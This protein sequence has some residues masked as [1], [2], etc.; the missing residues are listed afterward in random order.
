[1]FIL[2]YAN[3]NTYYSL[4]LFIKFK[5]TNSDENL[6]DCAFSRKVLMCKVYLTILVF[7]SS[8]KQVL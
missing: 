7:K 1:M 8:G 2:L 3:S 4:I 6:L 5:N